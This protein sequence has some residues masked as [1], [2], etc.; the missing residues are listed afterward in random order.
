MAIIEITADLDCAVPTPVEIPIPAG[1]ALPGGALRLREEGGSLVV[2]AQLSG[3]ELVAILPGTHAGMTRR[4]HLEADNAAAAE[5]VSLKEE[6][7]AKLAIVLPDGVFTVYNYAAT[8]PRPFFYPVLGPGRKAVTRNYPMK[9]VEGED[10]DHPHHRSFLPSIELATR[11][12]RMPPS[13]VSP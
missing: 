13:L 11:N 4:F 9:D 7:E 12:A 3:N 5:G 2:P 6:G 1:T 8:E 10:K